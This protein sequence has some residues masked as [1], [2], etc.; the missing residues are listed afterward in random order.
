[1]PN[2]IAAFNDAQYDIEHNPYA[3]VLC[4]N[5]TNKWI[6]CKYITGHEIET[7]ICVYK[8]KVIFSAHLFKTTNIERERGIE[9]NRYVTPVP[10]LSAEQL[11]DLNSEIQKLGKVI[12]DHVMKPCGKEMLVLHPEYKI[13]KENKAYLLECAFR[14]GGGLNP[15]C[16]EY[17]TGI[18]PYYLSA[19]ATLNI[20]PKIRAYAE[21]KA[22][23]YQMLL[24]DKPRIF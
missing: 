24:S 9:E 3:K 6:V 5:A 1:M 15:F 7:E 10:W 18:N 21:K 19:Q 11:K 23:G 14:N 12:Y 16:I 4:C 13:D 2:F 22:A 20:A 8:G 17:S